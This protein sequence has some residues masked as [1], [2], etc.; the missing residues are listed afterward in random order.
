MNIAIARILNAV[1]FV[2][3][4]SP[5]TQVPVFVASCRCAWR[6]SSAESCAEVRDVLTSE[7]AHPRQVYR[8]TRRGPTDAQ[9]RE[10]RQTIIACF[11]HE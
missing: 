5:R 4:M 3:M 6:H 11:P 2:M 9:L 8:T 7:A 1:I 10:W